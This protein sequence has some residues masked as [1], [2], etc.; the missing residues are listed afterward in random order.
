MDTIDYFQNDTDR[1]QTK[2]PELHILISDE[3]Q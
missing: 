1:Q 2:V 3:N